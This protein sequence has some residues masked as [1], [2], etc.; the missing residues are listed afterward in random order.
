MPFGEDSFTL[1]NVQYLTT[2]QVLEDYVEL[3]TH[4]KKKLNVESCPVVAFGGSYGGTLTTFM[5]ASYPNVIVG[6]LAASAPI[7]YYDKDGWEDH[8]VDEFTWSDII[9]KVYNEADDQCLDY[10][11]AAIDAVNAA[12]VNSLVDLFNTC[13]ASTFSPKDPVVNSD[14]FIYALEGLP[15]QN[16]PYVASD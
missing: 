12:D 8:G 2:E 10:I 13:D 6:G 11:H 1:E 9:T 14:L 3:V 4:L 15:Q 7:G 16:Y 5:R